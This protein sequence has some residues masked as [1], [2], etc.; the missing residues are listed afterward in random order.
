MYNFGGQKK[1]EKLCAILHGLLH[2]WSYISPVI[3]V[4]SVAGIRNVW[5]ST[6]HHM[7]KYSYKN[8]EKSQTFV[9]E[10]DA[11]WIIFYENV[12]PTLTSDHRKDFIKTLKLDRQMHVA[13]YMLL[14]YWKKK[15]KKI[16][17]PANIYHGGGGGW[18]RIWGGIK[19]FSG[20]TEGESN[21]T[22]R[23]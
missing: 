6:R 21:V 14:K 7:A 2:L 1:K 8:W 12:Y 9:E 19:E 15:G 18:K 22:N 11:I 10:K 16:W 13:C 23:V 4:S 17:G 20:G 5:K 3:G